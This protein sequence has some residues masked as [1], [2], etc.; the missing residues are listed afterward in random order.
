MKRS[1]DPAKDDKRNTSLLE[2]RRIIYRYVQYW[3]I[4]SW[5]LYRYWTKIAYLIVKFKFTMYDE[6]F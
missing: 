2:N 3:Y 1:R 5:G 6:V 4:C